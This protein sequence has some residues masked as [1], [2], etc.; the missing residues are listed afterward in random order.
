M[1]KYNNSLENTKNKEKRNNK[2]IDGNIFLIKD[3]DTL[4]HYLLDE[5]E[6]LL[7]EDSTILVV[8]K[9]LDSMFLIPALYIANFIYN[10]QQKNPKEQVDIENYATNQ[11][12]GFKMLFSCM[13]MI[14]NPE[15]RYLI[16]DFLYNIKKTDSPI[17]Q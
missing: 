8:D 16:R 7:T 5:E 10:R 4:E 1:S 14:S 13:Q 6:G 11:N 9:N 2:I 12:E 3:F 17:T 15:T